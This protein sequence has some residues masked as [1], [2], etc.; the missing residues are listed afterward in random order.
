MALG[1]ACRRTRRSSAPD[2]A[3]PNGV[4]KARWTKS[5]STARTWSTNALN[6][7]RGQWEG[8][9]CNYDLERTQDAAVPKSTPQGG[10]PR[11]PTASRSTARPSQP[12]T[13]MS[14][15]MLARFSLMV[16]AK[17]QV[18]DAAL[19]AS[20]TRHR[21]VGHLPPLFTRKPHLVPP[22]SEPDDQHL[23]SRAEAGRLR[24][25]FKRRFR[26]CGTAAAERANAAL[27]P[28]FVLLLVRLLQRVNNANHAQLLCE[29]PPLVTAP[30]DRSTPGLSHTSVTE[31][32]TRCAL[33]ARPQ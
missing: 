22:G 2:T 33:R 28:G 11:V 23:C 4:T 5:R 29:Q 12:A 7:G 15:S 16:A 20:C 27:K 17:L 10:L 19:S 13:P 1:L 21:G 18:E 14:S 25:S 32:I 9:L 8:R 30:G 31:V 3:F 24:P 26:T 6:M